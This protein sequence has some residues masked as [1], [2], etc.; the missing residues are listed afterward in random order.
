ML[1]TL[2]N[3]VRHKAGGYRMWS[4]ERWIQSVRFRGKP[5]PPLA[6]GITVLARNT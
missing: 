4:A 5:I 1:F 2:L 6:T 3:Y